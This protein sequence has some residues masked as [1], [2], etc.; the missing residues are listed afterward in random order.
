MTFFSLKILNISIK[1][2][3]INV[4]SIFRCIYKNLFRLIILMMCMFLKNESSNKLYLR[5]ILVTKISCWKKNKWLQEWE[6]GSK[7]CDLYS[8]CL[9]TKN[10]PQEKYI[11]LSSKL[12]KPI[13]ISSKFHKIMVVILK[14]IIIFFL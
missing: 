9:D 1:D 5:I 11:F 6:K 13:S 12:S 14:M 7:L 8:L 3:N 4:K 10:Q 2:N